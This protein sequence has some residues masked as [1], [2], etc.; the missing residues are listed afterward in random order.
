MKDLLPEAN[1]LI[2]I[3]AKEFLRDMAV[4]ASTSGKFRSDTRY[5]ATSSKLNFYVVAAS[6]HDGLCGQLICPPHRNSPVQVE[7]RARRWNC[8]IDPS[9][10]MYV[11]ALHFIFDE[12]LAAYN[13]RHKRRYRLAVDVK[14]ASEPLLSP[15]AKD[16]FDAFA[17]DAAS[18]LNVPDW[19]R[20]YR[21]ARVCHIRR[22]K[23]NEEDVF[24]LL[25][26][27]SLSEETSRHLATIFGHLREFQRTGKQ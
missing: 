23:T 6:E 15:K 14:G 26:H 12:L 24:R 16:A 19:R 18:G 9:Y 22:V 7:V 20:F 17:A 27:A 8:G 13:K 2:A 21:F 10:E 11:G 3:P 5:N 1:I 4:I 25:V